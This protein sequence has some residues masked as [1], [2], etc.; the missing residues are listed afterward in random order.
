M[1][2]PDSTPNVT[3][4]CMLIVFLASFGAAIYG[5]AWLVQAEYTGTARYLSEY[6]HLTTERVTRAKEPARFKQA[7]LQGMFQLILPGSVAVAALY[8]YR[9]LS[10]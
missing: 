10:T 5:A 8:F 9:R 6:P 7:E 1:S 2:Y 3:R 4:W